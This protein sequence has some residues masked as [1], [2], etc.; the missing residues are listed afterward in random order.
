MKPCT[1]TSLRSSARMSRE[2]SG[3]TLSP[4]LTG[5]TWASVFHE[6]TPARSGNS[7]AL[8]SV[9][10]GSPLLGIAVSSAIPEPA[11]ETAIVKI[12]RFRMFIVLPSEECGPSVG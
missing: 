12:A 3:T 9:A 7:V 1:F 6:T 10:L 5:W 2:N 11:H 4:C 8:K